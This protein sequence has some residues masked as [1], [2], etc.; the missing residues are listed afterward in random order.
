M[1]LKR[2]VIAAISCL[3]LVAVGIGIEDIYCAYFHGRSG[4]TLLERSSSAGGGIYIV[5][6]DAPSD[7]TSALSDWAA[8]N[9][10]ALAVIGDSPGIAVCDRSGSIKKLLEKAGAEKEAPPL[11]E[12]MNGVY[13]TNDAAYIGAYVEDG[14]FMPEALALPVLGYYDESKL[15]EDLRRPFFYPLSVM[16]GRGL[17]YSTDAEELSG[18]E[19]LIKEAGPEDEITV[20][21][22][23]ISMGEL[24][25]LLI[26][27]PIEARS[28]TTV[29]CT[30]VSLSLC[31]VFSGLM[32]Y[33]E[34]RRELVIRHLFGM[35]LGKIRAAAALISAAVTG[36]SLLLFVITVRAAGHV[37]LEGR[38]LL[39]I[40]CAAA[41]VYILLAAI[42]NAAGMMGLM[43]SIERGMRCEDFDPG[44]P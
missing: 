6:P 37:R 33:R 34:H 4:L 1:R 23:D 2:A 28:R 19:R 40:A 39:I 15:P 31:F 7:D 43:G 29:F 12:S 44:G 22:A 10:A 27:D 41:A 21:S 16:A 13:V 38:E 11:D 24:F 42:V 25:W 17:F 5:G 18:L 9:R 3:L 8:E 36:A 35:S 30:I 32:L 14:V 26:H 20:R